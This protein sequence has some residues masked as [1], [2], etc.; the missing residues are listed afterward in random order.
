MYLVL[1]GPRS[2]NDLKGHNR[3]FTANDRSRVEIAV[4]DDQ[5]FPYLELLTRHGFR[6]R[7]FKDIDDIQAI[8]AYPIV[9]CDIK[10]V[11]KHFQSRYEGAHLISEFRKRYPAKI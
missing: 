3:E 1:G 4:I 6:L 8:H 10:G 11:G 5:E 2:I 7:H 9:L